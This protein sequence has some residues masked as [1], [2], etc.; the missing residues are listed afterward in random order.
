MSVEMM[1]IDLGQIDKVIKEGRKTNYRRHVL[2]PECEGARHLPTDGN[3]RQ[4]PILLNE[5]IQVLDCPSCLK[6]A[7]RMRYNAK[8]RERYQARKA[9]LAAFV[10][11]H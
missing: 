1:L 11:A 5:L 8:R 6:F 3:Y 10:V 2:R 7:K 4:V 9:Q